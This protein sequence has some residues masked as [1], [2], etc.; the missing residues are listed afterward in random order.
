MIG[1]RHLRVPTCHVRGWTARAETR[2]P[3]VELRAAMVELQE[4]TEPSAD[5]DVAA[6]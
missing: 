6:G 2:G 4:A 3:C 5:A 1:M